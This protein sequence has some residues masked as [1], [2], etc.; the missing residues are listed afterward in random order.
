M[1][2]DIRKLRYWIG[3]TL[4]LLVAAVSAFFLY[5]RYRLQK[6]VKE[7]P[8]RL[9]VE[10]Q[11]TAEGWTLSRSVGGRTVF[12]A[13]ASHAVRFREGLTAELRDVKIVVYGRK[14]DRFDQIY[15]AHFVYDQKA[16]EIRAPG[17]V[18]IDLESYDQG[19]QTPDQ[20]PPAEL[21]NPI[22][23]KT[24]GLVFNTETGVARTDQKIE[25]RVPQASGSAQG[26]V[27]EA[28]AKTLTL[29]SNVVVHTTGESPAD[30]TAERAV[31]NPQRPG[32][33]VLYN[34]R[35]EQDQRELQ[36]DQAT[37]E[38]GPE[39][40]LERIVAS[41]AVQARQTAAQ[42]SSQVTAPRVD[43]Y[44]LPRGGLQRAVLSGGVAV[45]GTG[46][47]TFQGR[48][49]QAVLTFGPGSELRDVRTSGEV[50]LER[51]RADGQSILL[52]TAA[53]DFQV[54]ADGLQHA[55]SL[56]DAAITVARPDQKTRTIASAVRISADFDRRGRLRQVEGRPNA[57]I[58][59]RQPGR[60]EQVSTSHVLRAQFRP[61]G[62]LENI[63][64]EGQVHY[65][66]GERQAQADKARYE[67]GKGLLILTGASRASEGPVSVS[68][69]T[70]QFELD[71]GRLSAEGDVKTTYG[72]VK[73][74]PEGAL[75]AASDPIHVTAQ[76]MTAEQTSGVARYSGEVRLWQGTSVIQAPEMAFSRSQRSVQATALEK[77]PV[78]T[79]F[80][81]KDA[82]GR[83]TPVSV[84][85]RSLAYRDEERK[86][87]FHGGVE[88]QGAGLRV[89]ADAVDVLLRE[90]GTARVPQEEGAPASIER[91]I[92]RG[93][94][95]IE[96]EDRVAQG[97]RLVY[98]AEAGRLEL[99]GGSPS[100][101]DAE[102]GKITGD[103]LTFFTRDDRVLVGSQGS[104]HT[105]TETRVKP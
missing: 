49:Q 1:F 17:E 25:F 29:T 22:H 74:Q 43:F 18:H 39:N 98:L 95:R 19:A 33:G 103:S 40:R 35:I 92:A 53:A 85:A 80:V 9:G 86:A 61:D 50:R 11:Q 88:L 47:S 87:S 94:I 79:S 6:V 55:Q 70:L 44:F 38:L 101:F 54:G 66:G 84:T 96:Q 99:T 13:Q 48:A 83:L 3:L 7:V 76:R 4:L 91:V 81:Q 78:R 28:K 68:A 102:L 65:R 72:D 89:R 62:E 8:A 73:A 105:V 71:S 14:A 104:S 58:V 45:I 16:G 77:V 15:G 52:E 64:Q 34:V 69:Q 63:S 32:Q 24:S 56:A 36:A 12:K 20:A 51:R 5:G 30:V 23:L 46:P 27:Y 41:G 26:A 31:I 59:H 93:S 10:I 21:K 97:E 37:I 67:P 2:R 90:P 60:P 100:I 75:L 82:E 42:Q 57:H